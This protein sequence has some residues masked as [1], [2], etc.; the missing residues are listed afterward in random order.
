MM[1]ITGLR[2][3]VRKAGGLSLREKVALRLYEWAA[4]IT[5]QVLERGLEAEMRQAQIIEQV[6][7]ELRASEMFEGY[8]Q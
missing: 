6:K 1:M 4:P 2:E 5:H 7:F 8:V 3:L